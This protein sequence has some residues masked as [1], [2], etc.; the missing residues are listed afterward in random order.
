LNGTDKAEVE[1]WLLIV[2]EGVR[3]GKVNS[4][5]GYV[6][7]ALANKWTVPPWY[8]KDDPARRYQQGEFADFWDA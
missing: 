2:A 3:L 1:K 5:P 7:D 8:R 6:R 4:P